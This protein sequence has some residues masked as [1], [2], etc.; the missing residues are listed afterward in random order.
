[1]SLLVILLVIILVTGLLY[2]LFMSS[3]SQVF[4]RVPYKVSTDD[5]VI[6]L[7]FD[8]GPNE[9]YT[10]QILEYLDGEGIKA[11][12]FQVGACVERY[13]EISKKMMDAGH[14]IGNHSLSHLFR[15]YF[16]SLSFEHEIFANQDTLKQHLGRTPALFRSP[17]LFRHPLLLKTLRSQGLQPVSGVFCHALEVF[18]PD[19]RRIAKRAIAKA[20]P[21]GILIFH[22]GIEGRGGDRQQTV[23]AVKLTV[24][25]LKKRGYSF[26]T[27]DS[28]LGVHPYQDA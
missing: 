27:V 17:W 18:Q 28:L 22:D 23:N 5:R 6:A 10:S 2:W 21:G 25:E 11:T 14:V 19:A 15:N 7:T 26:V 13:P 9:P 4:G 16:T 3:F 8:D 24:A 1:M 12:F 20:K